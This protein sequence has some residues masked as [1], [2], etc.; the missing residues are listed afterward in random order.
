MPTP[1]P[2]AATPPP[3]TPPPVYPAP[4]QQVNLWKGQI[5]CDGKNCVFVDTNGNRYICTQ[6][7]PYDGGEYQIDPKLFRVNRSAPGPGGYV[8]AAGVGTYLR[9]KVLPG[10]GNPPLTTTMPCDRMH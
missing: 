4:P 7:T 5:K 10:G 8:M 3:A 2:P 9:T 1:V 6:V